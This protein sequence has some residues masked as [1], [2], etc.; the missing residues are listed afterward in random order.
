MTDYP[1]SPDEWQALT[2]EG[3]IPGGLGELFEV[4]CNVD[5]DTDFLQARRVGRA[6]APTSRAAVYVHHSDD[7]YATVYIAAAEARQLAAHLLNVA[8][9]IDGKTPLVFFPRLPS[10]EEAPEVEEPEI[11]I[12]DDAWKGVFIGKRAVVTGNRT[13]DLVHWFPIGEVVAITDVIVSDDEAPTMAMAE[14]ATV[15]EEGERPLRQWI[16]IRDLMPLDEES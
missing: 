11:A 4:E 5:P 3:D 15:S 14:A 12:L 7:M 9:E 8:D 6:N 16:N 2:A 13:D 10:G 1:V